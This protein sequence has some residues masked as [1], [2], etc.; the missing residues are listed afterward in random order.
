M[1]TLPLLLRNRMTSD[2]RRRPLD[3]NVCLRLPRRPLRRRDAQV[4]PQRLRQRL[5]GQRRRGRG[6]R[7]RRHR[8]VLL[9]P[10]ELLRE[11]IC[12]AVGSGEPGHED[13]H[14]LQEPN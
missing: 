2:W 1:L 5:P 3:Q 9:Q 12:P 14:G 13:C 10:G 8:D 4:P 7:G 6:R 11:G